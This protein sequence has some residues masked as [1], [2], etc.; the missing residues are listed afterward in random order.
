M[1]LQRLPL[2]LAL[3]GCSSVRSPAQ[4]VKV[5]FPAKQRFS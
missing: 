4:R 1:I 5:I 3:M 2:N